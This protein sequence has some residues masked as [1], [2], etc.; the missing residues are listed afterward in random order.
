MQRGVPRETLVIPAIVEP[1]AKA[2]R[3]GRLIDLVNFVH[4]DLDRHVG[5]L[6]GLVAVDRTLG[7]WG[8]VALVPIQEQLAQGCSMRRPLDSSGPGADICGSNGPRH[9]QSHHDAA[10]VSRA[11]HGSAVRASRV[12]TSSYLRPPRVRAVIPRELRDLVT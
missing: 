10:N 12:M 2:Q 7:V 4:A 11:A 8:L 9:A 3:A 1:H 5:A 6:A